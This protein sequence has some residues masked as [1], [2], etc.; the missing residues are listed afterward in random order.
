MKT[1]LKKTLTESTSTFLSSEEEI[2]AWLDQYKIKDYTINGDMTVSV[3][4]GFAL[5]DKGLEEIP[6]KFAEV[7]GSIDVTS[8]R[9]KRIDWAPSKIN[10]DFDIWDNE[11]ETL[12]GGPTEV[13][14]GYDCDNNRLT[15]LAG[16]PTKVGGSFVCSGNKLT[17]LK[18]CPREVGKYFKAMSCGLTSIDDLPESIGTNLYLNINELTSLKGLNKLLKH[19]AH[20]A[21][22][23]KDGVISITGNPISGSILS[24]LNIKGFK[25]LSFQARH[26]S[27]ATPDENKVEKAVKIINAAVNDGTDVFDVQEQLI[28]K[29]LEE[30]A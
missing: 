29:D 23:S 2:R 22:N 28:A 14:G 20:N 1:T 26:R 12:E 10:G 11:I 5:D 27:V 17:S 8:N 4:G 3:K 30:F 24:V 15:S 21:A 18:G 16:A 19:F 9:I 6:V 7:G 13:T 25:S